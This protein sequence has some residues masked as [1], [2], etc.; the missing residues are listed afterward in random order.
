MIYVLS[1]FFSYCMACLLGVLKTPFFLKQLVFNTSCP[2]NC[3]LPQ[4]CKDILL[5]LVLSSAKYRIAEVG[6]HRSSSQGPLFIGG[7]LVRWDALC[8]SVI[9]FS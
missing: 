1:I 5:L 6:F 9:I 3:S 2:R 4:G 8:D 7:C